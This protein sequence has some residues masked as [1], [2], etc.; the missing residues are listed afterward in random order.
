MLDFFSKLG[1]LHVKIVLLLASL[2][3]LLVSLSKVFLDMI[4]ALTE[5]AIP[6][7]GEIVVPDFELQMA[8]TL[9]ILSLGNHFFPIAEAWAFIVASVPIFVIFM[10]IRFIKSWIPTMA[11]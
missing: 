3:A 6:R 9:E 5:W 1:A 2:F 8:D 7:I 10:V 11:N 4:L